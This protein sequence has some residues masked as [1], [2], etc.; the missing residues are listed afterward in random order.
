LSGHR[1]QAACAAALAGCGRGEDAAQLDDQERER[2]RSL[3]RRW[4]RD[5]LT[6]W[7]RQL[8]NNRP[9]LEKML[10]RWQCD[11]D[12]AAVREPEPLAKLPPVEQQAWRQF[13]ADV[14]RALW[15][16]DG[17]QQTER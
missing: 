15:N 8:A 9:I 2:L 17:V 4:L 1:Y 11:Q 10:R 5:E 7:T 12:L 3:A 14:T 6:L 13:W 16:G